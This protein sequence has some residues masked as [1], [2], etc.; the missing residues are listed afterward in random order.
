MAERDQATDAPTYRRLLGLLAL[1]DGTAPERVAEWL[2]VSR[3]SLYNWADRYVHAGRPSALRTGTH[4][5]RPPLWD[6]DCTALLRASLHQTPEQFGF[7]AVNWTVGLL[8]HQLGRCVGR[9]VS[10]GTLRRRLHQLG[11]VWKRPRYV[12]KADPQREKKD[13]FAPVV[14]AAA[15]AQRGPV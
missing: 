14:L 13:A 15:S 3:Q 12:L 1:A 7:P 10:E 9:G 8:Q 2:G 6:E 5:G 11:Y 4:P